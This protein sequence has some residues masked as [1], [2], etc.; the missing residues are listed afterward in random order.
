MKLTC[1]T[2]G[3]LPVWQ[4]QHGGTTTEIRHLAN[5]AFLDGATACG[6][7]LSWIFTSDRVENHSESV[8]GTYSLRTGASNGNS[9]SMRSMPSRR[10]LTSK[11]SFHVSDPLKPGGKAWYR[12]LFA[13]SSC[14]KMLRTAIQ[15]CSSGRSRKEIQ[16][17]CSN[18]RT[19]SM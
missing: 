2:V 10:L 11:L 12:N 5:T 8:V 1:C 7:S 18:H 19:V 6:S 15:S 4:E 9:A 14:W 3:K 13:T 16:T 17:H